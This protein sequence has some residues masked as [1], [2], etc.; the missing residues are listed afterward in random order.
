MIEFVCNRQLLF[1]I[2]L[3]DLTDSI[4]FLKATNRFENTK[5]IQRSKNWTLNKRSRK[6]NHQNNN[7]RQRLPYGFGQSNP[8]NLSCRFQ[9]STS[10]FRYVDGNGTAT[11]RFRVCTRASMQMKILRLINFFA[12]WRTFVA[13][14]FMR[15]PPAIDVNKM[16][17]GFGSA[18]RDGCS[19]RQNVCVH[20]F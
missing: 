17:L 13:F 3:F 6:M 14:L 8:F 2:F 20:A 18:D 15:G 12:F 19:R 16:K 9:S 5:L 10:Q 1:I 11:K 4:I 7:R